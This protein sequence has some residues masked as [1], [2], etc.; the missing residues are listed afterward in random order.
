MVPGPR[1]LGRIQGDAT[2]ESRREDGLDPSANGQKDPHNVRKGSKY[3]RKSNL[4]AHNGR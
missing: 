1:G 3:R 4:L 2:A